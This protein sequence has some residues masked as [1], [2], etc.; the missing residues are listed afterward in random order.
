[1]TCYL[2]ATDIN[3]AALTHTAQTLAA[4]KVTGIDLLQTDL[5]AALLPRLASA[6]DLLVFNPPY[7]PTPDEEVTGEGIV[8]SWAGGHRGRRVIDRLLTQLDDVLAPGGQLW[9]VTVQQ[10]DPQGII[11][12]MQ[13]KGYAGETS[14]KSGYGVCQERGGAGKLHLLEHQLKNAGPHQ[15][16]LGC[17]TCLAGRIVMSRGADEEALSIVVLTRK[18]TSV[19]L[20]KEAQQ[21]TTGTQ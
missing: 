3:A 10:N 2:V 4:H 19:T 11:E 15:H 7:V 12:E 9:L 18:V 6:V 17:D 16:A 5:L 14:E 8:R 21:E 13:S 1:M 20:G